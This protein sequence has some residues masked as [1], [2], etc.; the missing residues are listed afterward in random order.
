MFSQS[1]NHFRSAQ[2]M[3]WLV[4]QARCRNLRLF[5]VGGLSKA[6]EFQLRA[7]RLGCFWNMDNYK[8]SDW[9]ML[10]NLLQNFKDGRDLRTRFPTH[11]CFLHSFGLGRRSGLVLFWPSA[12]SAGRLAVAW[13]LPSS[14]PCPASSKLSYLSSWN[15]WGAKR[16]K[17]AK[18]FEM[19]WCPPTICDKQY[20]RQVWNSMWQCDSKI[21]T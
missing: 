4:S 9:H 13:R 8:G 1:N 11:Q 19:L 20:K 21:H 10:Q 2:K 3:V 7:G 14:S 5:F 17:R 6:F 12:V 18:S 15:P 16:L